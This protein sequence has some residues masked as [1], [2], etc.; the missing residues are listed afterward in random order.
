METLTKMTRLKAESEIMG[1]PPGMWSCGGLS[2][3]GW[4]KFMGGSPSRSETVSRRSSALHE[5]T[6][7]RMKPARLLLLLLLLLFVAIIIIVVV[8]VVLCDFDVCDAA[9]PAP[10]KALSRLEGHK[11]GS[12]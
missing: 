3:G 11:N 9:V 5:D 10:F 6:S 8:V 2:D 4:A 7:T 12:T 1:S